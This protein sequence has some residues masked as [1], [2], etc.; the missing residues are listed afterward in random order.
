MFKFEIGSLF[1]CLNAES[2]I[3]ENS[4]NQISMLKFEAGSLCLNT[5]WKPYFKFSKEP[6]LLKIE[7]PDFLVKI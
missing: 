1:V 3:Y 7:E 6:D 2:Q 4:R 5:A